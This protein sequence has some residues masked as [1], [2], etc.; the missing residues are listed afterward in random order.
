[1]PYVLKM[2][3]DRPAVSD[4]YEFFVQAMKS[5]LI[6]AHLGKFNRSEDFIFTLL[7]PDSKNLRKYCV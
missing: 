3:D 6:Q 4:L 2:N 7:N 1:M 5:K